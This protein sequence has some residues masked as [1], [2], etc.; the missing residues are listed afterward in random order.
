VKSRYMLDTNICIYIARH[1]PPEV[2]ARFNQMKPGELIM[3]V[4]T[5][6]E[7]HCGAMKCNQ[8]SVALMHL[9]ELVKSIP[10]ESLDSTVALKYGEIRAALQKQGSL[11]GGNDLWIG[12]HAL[13]LDVILVTSNERELSRIAGLSVENWTN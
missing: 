7:L 6:G 4:V 1:G 12:A 3:S 2:M 13:A 8:Q 11:I 9:D 5:Y 10:A